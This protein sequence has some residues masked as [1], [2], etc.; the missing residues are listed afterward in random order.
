MGF[1][2]S[3]H[4]SSI[5][6]QKP[7]KQLVPQIKSLRNNV[8][9]TLVG[10]FG[11]DF[12]GNVIG[13]ILFPIY[14]ITLAIGVGVGFLVI[15]VTL[16]TVWTIGGFSFLWVPVFIALYIVFIIRAIVKK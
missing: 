11:I 6:E 3:L 10:V 14:L 2:K 8:P 16:N 13:K 12:V 1:V 7:L 4:D 5:V 15:S 9:A